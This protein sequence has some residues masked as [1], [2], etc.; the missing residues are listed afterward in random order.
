[1]RVQQQR[2]VVIVGRVKKS[3]THFRLDNGLPDTYDV[4]IKNYTCL[5][6]LRPLPR[7][8]LRS[9]SISKIGDRF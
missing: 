8:I 3:R 7:Y 2:I 6:L 4:S 9:V 5:P 1:M